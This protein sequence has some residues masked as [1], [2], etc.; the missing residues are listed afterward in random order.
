M[1]EAPTAILTV[2]E[3]KE[4]AIEDLPAL[5][6]QLKQTVTGPTIL[7]SQLGEHLLR[8]TTALDRRLNLKRFGGLRKF[9]RDYLA[10]LVV[11]KAQH[12]PGQPE[13]YDVLIELPGEA[14]STTSRVPLPFTPRNARYFW[15]A[16][17]NP[18]SRYKLAILSGK[19]ICHVKGELPEGA[20]E[21]TPFTFDDYAKLAKNFVASLPASSRATGDHL[22]G[23]TQASDLHPKFMLFLREECGPAYVQKW[24]AIRKKAAVNLF[25]ERTTTTGISEPQLNSYKEILATLDTRSTS[26]K[27]IRAANTPALPSGRELTQVQSLAIKIILQMTDD[28]IRSLNFPF[29]LVVDA[30]KLSAQ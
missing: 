18:Q 1:V 25:A 14:S 22:I 20:T 4:F 19:I 7:G 15:Y 16:I 8:T 24:D 28:Q 27:T 12:A 17:S 23:S 6:A 9:S 26:N 29:G 2:E 3:Q 21:F 13:I 5:L 30:T 11:L 10:D